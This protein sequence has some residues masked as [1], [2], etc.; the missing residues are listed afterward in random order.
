MTCRDEILACVTALVEQKG[1]NRFSL[2]E[3]LDAMQ[4]HGTT[5]KDS[6]IRTHVTSRMCAGTPQHH[7]VRYEDLDRIGP[8]IYSIR[9]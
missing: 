4:A 8:G 5:Y 2:R 9:R 1:E 7:A 6:T 3:V